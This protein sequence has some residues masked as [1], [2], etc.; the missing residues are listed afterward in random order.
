MFG[1]PHFSEL[2]KTLFAAQQLCVPATDWWATYTSA[3]QDNH[4]VS[5]SE[6][7]KAFR[8][9]HLS[10]GIVCRKLLEFLHLRQGIESVNEYIRKFNYL[11]QYGG[12]HIDTDEKKVELSRNRLSLQM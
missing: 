2:Q 6:F 7:Y 12:Y 10:V 4:Q 9:H 8:E 5:W 11:Q 1:L 3:L